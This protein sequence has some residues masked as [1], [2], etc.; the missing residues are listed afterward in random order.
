[1]VPLHRTAMFKSS[2][3][4]EEDSFHHQSDLNVRKKLVKYYILS[5]ALYG[6]KPLTHWKADQKYLE[7]FEMW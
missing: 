5:I 7:N 1:M 3:Q 4:Q 2:I 6:A